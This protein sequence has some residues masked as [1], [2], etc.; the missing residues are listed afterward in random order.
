MCKNGRA[1]SD[2]R[3]DRRTHADSQ[4]AQ[5]LPKSFSLLQTNVDKCTIAHAGLH[6][7]SRAASGMF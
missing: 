3:T 4:I 7:C 2:A 6:F 5:C 1:G